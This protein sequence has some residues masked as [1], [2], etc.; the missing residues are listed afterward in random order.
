MASVTIQPDTQTEHNAQAST[1]VGHQP[2]AIRLGLTGGTDLLLD[3]PAFRLLIGAGSYGLAAASQSD[4]RFH[5]LRRAAESLA[6]VAADEPDA[7]LLIEED[8][9]TYLIS[10]TPSLGDRPLL[11]ARSVLA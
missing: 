7:Q 9:R 1:L 6:R 10:Q 4:E 5:A 11:R 3:L 2:L 8:G